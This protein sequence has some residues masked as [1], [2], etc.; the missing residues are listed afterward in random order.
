VTVIFYGALSRGRSKSSLR[1]VM[2][3][4][5]WNTPKCGYHFMTCFATRN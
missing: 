4:S 5:F 2:H 3:F 1:F